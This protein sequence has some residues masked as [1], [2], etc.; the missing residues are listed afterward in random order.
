MGHVKPRNNFNV[1]TRE[2]RAL[3]K[4]SVL[5]RAKGSNTYMPKIWVFL[6]CLDSI[7]YTEILGNMYILIHAW[8]GYAL[9]HIKE[10]DNHSY[11]C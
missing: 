1:N 9:E 4:P 8:K 5:L 2:Q 7:M 11:N 10:L 3:P 6:L